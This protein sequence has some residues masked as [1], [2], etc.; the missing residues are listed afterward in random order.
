MVPPTAPETSAL[1]HV[2]MKVCFQPLAVPASSPLVSIIVPVYNVEPYLRRC[3]DSLCNQTY[4]NLE[5]ICVNDG[6]TDN[7]LSILREYESTDGRIRVVDKPNG[8]V[9]S[10]RNAALDIATGDWVTAVDPDDYLE[11]DTYSITMSHAED[12]VDLIVYGVKFEVE[13]GSGLEAKV[14]SLHTWANLRLDG[15]KH[16]LTPDCYPAGGWYL[17]NKLYRRSIIEAHALRLDESISY[18]EDFCFHLRYCIHAR[19]AFYC[20]EELYVYFQ[21]GA[22]VINTNTNLSRRC[23]SYLK[24]VTNVLDA[25]AELRKLETWIPFW[26]RMLQWPAVRLYQLGTSDKKA[27]QWQDRYLQELF[28]RHLHTYAELGPVLLNLQEQLRRAQR[29]QGLFNIAFNSTVTSTSWERGLMH[30]AIPVDEPHAGLALLTACGL[31]TTAAPGRNV[32]VHFICDDISAYTRERLTAFAAEHI[33]VVLHEPAAAQ[34]RHLSPM[35]E[36]FPHRAH[37]MMMIPRLLADEERVLVLSPGVLLRGEL[38]PLDT[39]EMAGMAVARLMSPD[40][41]EQSQVSCPAGDHYDSHAVLL[42]DIKLTLSQ[43]CAET[44]LAAHMLGS[45]NVQNAES[46]SFNMG[47]SLTNIALPRC[48]ADCLQFPSE[49]ELEQAAFEQRETL[50]GMPV[51]IVTKQE[52]ATVCQPNRKAPSMQSEQNRKPE[53]V[54]QTNLK[55]TSM[56]SDLIPMALQYARLRRRYHYYK[57]MSFLTWGKKHRHYNE[58]KQ[59]YQQILRQVRHALRIKI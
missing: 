54:C 7:S 18:N 35:D 30:V 27:I 26:K 15:A 6:S 31:R 37:L 59:I 34:L 53:K 39:V 8:G 48:W 10:A 22:S 21:H 3:L 13:A 25:H 29:A 5:I 17:W 55:A 9:S 42:M 28:T 11:L 44:W 23:E 12:E 45:G 50:V 47:F 57:I 40:E 19:Q 49:K 14:K 43:K 58:K 38:L 33:S 41:N 46:D 2:S 56:Q 24:S 20:R 16:S 4:Q 52:V 1:S 51:R 36:A 32:C